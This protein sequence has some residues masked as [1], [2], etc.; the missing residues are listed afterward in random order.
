VQLRVIGIVVICAGLLLEIA[1]IGSQYWLGSTTAVIGVF[2][3]AWGRF[4]KS[5]NRAGD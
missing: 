4:G 3:Y 1:G 2:I 5:G